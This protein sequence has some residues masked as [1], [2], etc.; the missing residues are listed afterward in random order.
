MYG[1]AFGGEL[2]LQTFVEAVNARIKQLAEEM[3]HTSATAKANKV[4][5]NS[6]ADITPD[7]SIRTDDGRVLPYPKI[8]GAK[9]L[10]PCGAGGRVGIAY[11]FKDGDSCL[12][13]F[14]EGGAGM[15]LKWDLSGA[16]AI[17]GV[18]QA[19]PEQV[20]KAGREEA[21]VLFAPD[22]TVTVKKDKIE[23]KHKETVVTVM[24]DGI[25]AVRAGTSVQ[26]QSSGVS[27]KAPKVSIVGDVSV[28]G[29]ISI[30][31]NVTISGLLTAGG[32]TFNTHTHTTP[33]G[34]TGGP[35]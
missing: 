1:A 23:I 25:E 20:K 18:M 17:P 33:V 6:S 30:T 15:D 21:V 16:V 3:I 29:E 31:G 10:F 13:I 7:L 12:A 22:A 14:G 34:P 9:V 28:V 27:V 32:I 26:I 8:S 19:Y 5:D 35:V 11:P 4:S 2:M 24:P